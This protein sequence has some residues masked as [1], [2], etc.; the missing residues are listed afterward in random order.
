MHGMMTKSAGTAVLRTHLHLIIG[1]VTDIGPNQGSPDLAPAILQGAV[2][3]A[4]DSVLANA[5]YGADHSHCLCRNE[6]GTG[7]SIIAP[8]CRNTGRRRPK[9]AHRQALRQRFSCALH[10]RRW[11]I[12]SG[13]S[14]HKRRLWPALT[15]Q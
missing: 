12:E 9:T 15:A 7:R 8:K 14:Q 11:H 13:F 10:Q 3:I 1:A 2:I 4:S 5:G 6:F